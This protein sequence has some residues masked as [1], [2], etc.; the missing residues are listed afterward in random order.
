M[1]GVLMHRK[2]TKHPH[3]GFPYIDR[4][5]AHAEAYRPEILR[6]GH[7]IP[8]ACH[9]GQNKTYERISRHF[10]WPHLHREIKDYC[11]TC[12]K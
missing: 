1:N 11:A 4:V 9:M 5:V 6:V 10:F 8:F 2:F 12:P 7:A 3:D